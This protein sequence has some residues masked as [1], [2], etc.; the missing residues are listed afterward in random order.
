M[1]LKDLIKDSELLKKVEEN[2]NGHTVIIATKDEKYIKDDGSLVPKDKVNEIVSD[3]LREVTEQKRVLTESKQNLERQLSE[4][5]EQTKDNDSLN[6]K[7]QSMQTQLQEKDK[8]IGSI[9]KRATLERNLI[10]KAQAKYPDLVLT[11]IDLDK[12]EIENDAIKGFDD[13][14]KPIKESYPELFGIKQKPS[15][16]GGPTGDK[17]IIELTPQQKNE[18]DIMLAHLPGYE[19]EEKRTLDYIDIKGLNKK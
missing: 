1:E 16:D 15:G 4:L 18:R 5:K 13:L 19:D 3:R 11:K 6:Q 12:I 10:T 2:L 9:T 17:P 8:E 7:I 14:V